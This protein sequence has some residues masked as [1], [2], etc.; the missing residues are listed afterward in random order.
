MYVL[1]P[2]NSRTL[3]HFVM[4]LFFQS[5][6]LYSFFSFL[7]LFVCTVACVIVVARLL[8]CLLAGSK[9]KLPVYK[10]ISPQSKTSI[11]YTKYYLY[12]VVVIVV[13]LA[14]AVIIIAFFSVA[15]VVG[16]SLVVK[17]FLLNRC[18]F[19]M[20]A[21]FSCVG[22]SYAR[23]VSRGFVKSMYSFYYFVL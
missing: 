15:V 18:V 4:V 20:S 19:S 2:R 21:N 1:V 14:G 3:K 22:G 9:L 16:V 7:H 17:Q 5:A 6:H 13:V 8:A 10:K 12:D 23:V 11:L